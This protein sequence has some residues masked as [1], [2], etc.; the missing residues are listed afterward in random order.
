MNRYFQ[1]RKKTKP[2]KG[3]RGAILYVVSDK[4]G[5]EEGIRADSNYSKR[6]WFIHMLLFHGP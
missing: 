2:E 1:E 3:R 5:E 4:K 6:A